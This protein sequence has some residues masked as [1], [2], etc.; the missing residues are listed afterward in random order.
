[1]RN[2]KLRLDLLT[3]LDPQP[4]FQAQYQASVDSLTQYIKS[5]LANTLH[6][7][8]VSGNIAR[9]CAKDKSAI[10]LTLIINLP[11][12]A[13]EKSALNQIK[14]RIEQANNPINQVFIDVVLLVEA[15]DFKNI[16]YWGFFLKHDAVCLS[17][18]NVA[19]SFGRFEMSLDIIKAMIIK[20][21]AR[22]AL[23]RQKILHTTQWSIQLDAAQQAA[24]ILIR[25]SFALVA[26]KEQRWEDELEICANCFLAHY[27]KKDLEIKRLFYLIDQKKVAKRAVIDLIDQFK[28]W[29]DKEQT[30][31][32][33]TQDT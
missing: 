31:L 16:F 2:K 3:T 32:S 27:P 29:L 7:L 14:W 19:D 4:C 26:H 8:Y 9:R 33:Y 24:D 13:T 6:S 5:S 28:T 23:V 12:T 18:I 22:F 1:M 15:I 25:A 21:T 30:L 17:A 10:E 20:R 11:L